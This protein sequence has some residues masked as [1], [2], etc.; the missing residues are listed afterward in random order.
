MS[1][2]LAK[3]KIKFKK[4]GLDFYQIFIND[5]FAKKKNQKK[6]AVNC[7]I[8]ISLR[9]IEPINVKSMRNCFKTFYVPLTFSSAHFFIIFILKYI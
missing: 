4:I 7:E 2:K 6:T 3:I 8:Q 9:G 1:S 5:N